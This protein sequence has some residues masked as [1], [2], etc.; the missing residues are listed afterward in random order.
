MK[1]FYILIWWI[2]YQPLT[3]FTDVFQNIPLIIW[4]QT[5]QQKETVENTQQWCKGYNCSWYSAYQHED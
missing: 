1:Y 2:L 3:E 5:T 4:Y